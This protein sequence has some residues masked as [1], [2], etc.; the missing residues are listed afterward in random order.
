MRAP[1]RA[2]ALLLLLA[3]NAASVCAAHAGEW[4]VGL[5]R[6]TLRDP[7][8]GGAMTGFATYPTAAR[9]KS[10]TVGRFS[11]MAAE[12]AAPATE[13]FPLVIVS[14][15]TG[16]LPDVYR[17]LFEGLTARGFVVAG[18]A[19]PGDNYDDRSGS[20][21]DALLVDRPRH[22]SALIDALE[23]GSVLAPAIDAGK[24]GIVGHSAGGYAGILSAGGAP[25]FSQLSS[26]RCRR[27][28]QDPR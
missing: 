8:G 25:D 22:I 3:V 13:Q 1:G 16:A 12:G 2:V 14:H 11:M 15:G 24:I 23:A 9:P 5:K 27:T 7:V 26:G 18:I 19:H 4:K 28:G 20:F 17:W 6:L 10:L 21:G